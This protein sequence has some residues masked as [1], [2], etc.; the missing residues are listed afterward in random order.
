MRPLACVAALLQQRRDLRFGR[1]VDAHGEREE[2]LAE[3]GQLG[4]AKV[5]LVRIRGLGL[6]ALRE[7]VEREGIVSE[8]GGIAFVV[9]VAELLAEVVEQLIGHLFRH[10]GTS[11]A[12]LE[13]DPATIGAAGEL[14]FLATGPVGQA[15]VLGDHGEQPIHPALEGFLA[16]RGIELSGEH[17]LEATEREPGQHGRTGLLHA[18]VGVVQ[19]ILQRV[20]DL[21]QT[22]VAN[23]HTQRAIAFEHLGLEVLDQVFRWGFAV[24]GNVTHVTQFG[25]RVLHVELRLHTVI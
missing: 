22:R 17:L 2:E 25:D 5:K 1:V 7:R 21:W 13:Q 12:S 9:H 19:D 10:S 18:A 24:D 8:R 6:A 20:G 3:G 14:R 15:A 23:G 4:A 11:F 16:P